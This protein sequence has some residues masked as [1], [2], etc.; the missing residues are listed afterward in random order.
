M[1][2]RTSTSREKTDLGSAPAFLMCTFGS[3]INVKPR[4]GPSGQ[5]LDYDSALPSYHFLSFGCVCTF[6]ALSIVDSR[7]EHT[8]TAWN[9]T[10]YFVCLCSVNFTSL[11]LLFDVVY[12]IDKLIER[13]LL[14]L[15]DASGCFR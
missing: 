8:N 2:V 14:L 3:F 6:N 10:G 11:G 13:L 4:S 12:D 1:S 5:G 7:S 9:R 15:A